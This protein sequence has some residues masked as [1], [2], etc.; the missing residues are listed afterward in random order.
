MSLIYFQS[1]S[2][3][4]LG[5]SYTK[6]L[7]RWLSSKESPCQT[8]DTGSMSGSG[9]S[10]GEGKGNPLQYSCLANPMHREAWEAITHEVADSQI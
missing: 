4:V 8:G 9:R 3:S 5:F 2:Y 1:L 6:G 10:P 7:T